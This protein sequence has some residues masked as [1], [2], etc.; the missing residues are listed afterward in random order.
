MTGNNGSAGK[1]VQCD[2]PSLQLF[3]SEHYPNCS[4][5][6]FCR[7]AWIQ[8]MSDEEEF[9]D[10]M[11]GFVSVCNANRDT[12]EG[13]ELCSDQS[14]TDRKVTYYVMREDGKSMFDFPVLFLDG[15]LVR[16]MFNQ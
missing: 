14:L 9:R 16:E 5:T 15:D 12:P 1:L 10:A 4:L 7:G 11:E 2:M 6:A 13:Y 3:M 8:D